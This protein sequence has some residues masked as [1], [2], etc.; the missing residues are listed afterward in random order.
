V[1]ASTAE[2]SVVA[3]ECVDICDLSRFADDSFDAVVAYGGPL[4]YAFEEAEVALGEM[5]RVTSPGGVI[6]ASVMSTWGSWRCFIGG[7]FADA[8]RVSEDASDL[9]LSTGD[10]RHLG[11]PH[12][13]RMF[14]SRDIERMAAVAG[15]DLVAMS[16]SNWASL[17]DDPTLF[18][19][20]EADPDRWSRFVGHEIEACG[21]PGAVDGGTHLLFALRVRATN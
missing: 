16:A 1:G 7:V 9:A 20:V 17:S 15:V 13:C 8:E 4:S 2:T 18:E 6:V 3:R 5:V 11:G 14:R 10:L 12:V 19:S 21:E